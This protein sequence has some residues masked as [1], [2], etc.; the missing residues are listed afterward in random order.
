MTSVTNLAQNIET[1][2][3]SSHGRSTDNLKVNALILD[4]SSMVWSQDREPN[5]E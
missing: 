3:L 4:L 1:P 5:H 2:I